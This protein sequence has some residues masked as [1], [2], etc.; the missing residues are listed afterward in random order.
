MVNLKDIHFQENINLMMIKEIK[1]SVLEFSK[2]YVYT[3]VLETR[4]F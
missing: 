1:R 3:R 4:A 2:D